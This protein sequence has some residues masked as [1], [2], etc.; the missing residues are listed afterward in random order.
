MKDTIKQFANELSI[1]LSK[2]NLFDIDEVSAVI[3]ARMS[4]F[5]TTV[6]KAHSTDAENQ[7]IELLEKQSKVPLHSKEY[8]KIGYKLSLLKNKKARANRAVYSIKSVD[9]LPRL[10]KF[11]KDKYGVEVL[12]EFYQID[13]PTDKDEPVATS[14][15]H[16]QNK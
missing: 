8:V 9:Q 12:K 7:Y 13:E 1:E 6:V 5:V 3:S 10:K 14:R 16:K 4:G 15:S 11:I 2:R